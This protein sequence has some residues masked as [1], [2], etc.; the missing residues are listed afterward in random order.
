MFVFFFF[1]IIIV[2]GAKNR[3][4]VYVCEDYQNQDVAYM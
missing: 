3:E 1:V 4:T 2:G